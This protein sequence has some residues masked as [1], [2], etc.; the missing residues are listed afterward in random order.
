MENGRNSIVRRRGGCRKSIQHTLCWDC[1]NATNGNACPWVESFDPVPG[2]WA[3]PTVVKFF[4]EN[5][6]SYQ[7]VKCPLFVRDAESGGRK[8]M[9]LGGGEHDDKDACRDQRSASAP[10]GGVAE[11]AGAGAVGSGNRPVA[12][13]PD[14][15]TRL[16]KFDNTDEMMSLGYAIVESAVEDWKALDYG[17]KPEVM[18]DKGEFVDRMETVAFFFSK[19][20]VTLC[21][22]LPYTPEEIRAALNIPEEAKNLLYMEDEEV[23]KLFDG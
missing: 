18:V 19:W 2:W 7:V 1:A 23:E 4:R 15:R 17:R 5:T 14:R 3:R 6:D 8:K 20:F 22:H 11:S 12:D 9:P 16:L 13:R 21:S 10:V